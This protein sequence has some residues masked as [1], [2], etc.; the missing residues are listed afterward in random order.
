MVLVLSKKTKSIT[1]AAEV[2]VDL[3]NSDVL[4][5]SNEEKS[6]IQL[7]TETPIA[8]IHQI[9]KNANTINKLCTPFIA[10]KS[11]WVVRRNKSMTTIINKLE[12][13]HADF[14]DPHN[15]P[16]QSKSIYV[17]IL[18]CKYIRK[19]W[20]LSLRGKDNFVDT[21]QA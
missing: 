3:D 20:T 11:I 19:T 16:S 7:S 12:E 21:F 15:S 10:S 4:V 18:M 2:L 1:Q 8:A 17:V 13:V 9:I 14:W 5:S 6:P